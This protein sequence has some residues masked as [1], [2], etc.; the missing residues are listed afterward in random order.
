MLGADHI[1]MIPI[2]SDFHQTIYKR[3]QFSPFFFPLKNYMSS[4][5]INIL[6]YISKPILNMPILKILRTANSPL[7]ILNMPI[8]KILRTADSPL[9]ILT[10]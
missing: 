10:N 5:G 1:F 8:L 3:V 6:I 2:R 7:P 9:S 4:K